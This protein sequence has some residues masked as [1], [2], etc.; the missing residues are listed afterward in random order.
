MCPT[1]H[2]SCS[3]SV[4][5]EQDAFPYGNAGATHYQIVF[6]PASGCSRLI[7]Y[8]MWHPDLNLDYQF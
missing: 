6:L 2:A 4:S 5:S 3:L 1:G 7:L 8:H